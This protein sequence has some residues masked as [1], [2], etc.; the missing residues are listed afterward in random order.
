MLTDGKLTENLIQQ[1]VSVGG[2]SWLI[3]IDIYICDIGSL[4]CSIPPSAPCLRVLLPRHIF[5]TPEHLEP[6]VLYCCLDQRLPALA[7]EKTQ[8][9][10]NTQKNTNTW[11]AASCGS[12]FEVSV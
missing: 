9:G 10:R 8:Q 1:T 6:N 2:K 4:T 7:A 3:G 12:A 11:L 5:S